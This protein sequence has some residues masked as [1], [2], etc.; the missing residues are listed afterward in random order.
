MYRIYTI[1]IIIRLPHTNVCTQKHQQD[2]MDQW[3]SKVSVQIEKATRNQKRVQHAAIPVNT[4]VKFD[5]L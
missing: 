1:E 3:N 4:D 5:N 2:G